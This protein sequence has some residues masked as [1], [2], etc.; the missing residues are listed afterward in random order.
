M[1]TSRLMVAGVICGTA[2]S[3]TT[4]VQSVLPVGCDPYACGDGNSPLIDHRG[5]HDVDLL[6][7][8]PNAN[9]FRLVSYTKNGVPYSPVLDKAELTGRDQQGNIVLQGDTGPNSL[10]DSQFIVIN[11]QHPAQYI[12]KIEQVGE[13]R[14]WA[15]PNQIQRVTPS[16]M[17]TWIT[18]QGGQ[19]AQG[20]IWQNICS[21]PPA[22][23]HGYQI[24][25][26]HAVL[27]EG[28]KINAV[29]KTV[30]TVDT[31][32]LNIGCAGHALSKQHLHGHTEGAHH[33]DPVRFTTTLPERTAHLKMLAGDYC[34]NGIALTIAGHPLNYTDHRGWMPYA[35]ASPTLEARWSNTGAVCLNVPRITAAGLPEALAVFPNI[36]QS[37]RDACALAMKSRP[38][39]CPQP[40]TAFLGQH[41]LSANP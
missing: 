35:S 16:Y 2:P 10:I 6:F 19:P 39:A 25:R 40:D 5:V 27:F 32:W 31:R 12:I 13:A 28:D 34:G 4:A 24:D 38:R 17:L 33:I 30:E 8:L 3:A 18:A 22:D 26:F 7:A 23:L 14:F 11:V 36:E 15:K 1:N 41:I 29:T 37:I 21:S 20:Q 9:G